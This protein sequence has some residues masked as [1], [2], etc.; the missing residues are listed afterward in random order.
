[1]PGRGQAQGTA[2]GPWSRACWMLPASLSRK[3][4][5]CLQPCLG[6][7]HGRMSTDSAYVL[8]SSKSVCFF[9]FLPPASNY[10]SYWWF[11]LLGREAVSGS[12]IRPLLES[13][14]VANSLCCVGGGG[15][16]VTPYWH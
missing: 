12:R 7:M 16:T 9:L 10:F 2:L 5:S 1:M 15:R 4:V 13:L 8:S 14:P 11:V 6:H 3:A